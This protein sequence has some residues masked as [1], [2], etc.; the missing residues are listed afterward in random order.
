MTKKEAEGIGALI[1]I[2][3]IVYPFVWLYEQ[4]GAMGIVVCGVGIVAAFVYWHIHNKKQ[5]QKAFEELVLYTL[6]NRML[7]SGPGR[8]KL[9]N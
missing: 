7:I 8:T 6:H 2:V 4:I 3:V 1:V 9:T 5:D